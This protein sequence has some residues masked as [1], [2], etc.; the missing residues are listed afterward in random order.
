[1]KKFFALLLL[2]SVLIV[3][4]KNGC[5]KNGTG[6]TDEDPGDMNIGEFV[7]TIKNVENHHL[8]SVK[9]RQS[10]DSVLTATTRQVLTIFKNKQYTKLDSLIHPQEGIRF[11]P[12]ATVSPEDKKFSREAF[13]KSVTTNKNIMV[14]WGNYDGSGDPIELTPAEYFER[15]VYDANFINPD[16]YEVNN[17][18]Q[19]GNSSNNLKKMYDDSEFTE[20]H[21]AGSRKNGGLDW[22]SVRL[23]FKEING[24]YYLVG[25]VHDQWTI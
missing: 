6:S 22:K 12:Y 17:F 24:K 15:F 11:S 2:S 4:C 16:K 21:S 14:N 9:A 1:M 13:R 8:D 19:T 18:I 10:K 23:V 20:S 25:L 5:N 7:D 3:G